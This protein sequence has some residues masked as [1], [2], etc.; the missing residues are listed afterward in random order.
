MD[1]TEWAQGRGFELRMGN[2]R[3]TID[4]VDPFAGAF[5][6]VAQPNYS[7]SFELTVP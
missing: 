5:T 3:L 2:T 6:N 7:V 4:S 1:L